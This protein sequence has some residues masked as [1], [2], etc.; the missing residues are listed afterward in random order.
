MAFGGGRCVGC[1]G[2]AVVQV[3]PRQAAGRTASVSVSGLEA[4]GLSEPLGIGYGTPDF[5]LKLSGSDAVSIGF[6]KQI[7]ADDGLRAGPTARR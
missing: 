3:G 2:E 6:R 1:G 7:G 5:S 4:N